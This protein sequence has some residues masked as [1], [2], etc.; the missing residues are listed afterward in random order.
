MKLALVLAASLTL[1]AC[2]NTPVI[3]QPYEVESINKH[4]DSAIVY[5]GDYK[6]K[7]EFNADY[8]TDGNGVGHNWHDVE[9]NQI[10]DVKVFDLND[11]EVENYI[12][13]S[14]DVPA[15]VDAIEDFIRG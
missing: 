1:A 7:V 5:S 11:K 8:F 14:E 4:G 12:L 2:Q 3:N 6:L 13:Q 15:L 10:E 9:I